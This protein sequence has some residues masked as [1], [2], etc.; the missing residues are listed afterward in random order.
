MMDEGD[1][2]SES[3]RTDED[4]KFLRGGART[5]LEWFVSQTMQRHL[6]SSI[7]NG[8]TGF[9]ESGKAQADGRLGQ[10]WLS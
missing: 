9:H 6:Q 2:S 5:S 7:S 8:K 1:C 4:L 10:S 3:A